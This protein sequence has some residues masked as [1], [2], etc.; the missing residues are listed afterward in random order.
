MI[1][2][3]KMMKMFNDFKK[4]WKEMDACSNGYLSLPF[5]HPLE[6]HIGYHSSDEK[7]LVL[8]NSG[9]VENI[10]SSY[11]IKPVNI[12]LDGTWILEIRLIHNSYEDVFLRL[13]W[14]MIDASR[15]AE[16]SQKAFIN[17][18][19]VWQKL[20]QYM[21]NDVMSFHR[22]KG[23]LGELLYLQSLLANGEYEQNL[24]S[25]IGPEGGDQ[26]FVFE[27]SWS[28]IK[29]VPMASEV[30]TI[31]SLQQ[32]DR[33]EPGKLVVYFLESTVTAA[34]GI[35]LPEKVEEIRNLFCTETVLLD[36]FNM[37]LFMYGYRDK[38]SKEYLKNAFRLVE[39]REYYVKFDFPR[40][41]RKNTATVITTCTYSLSLAGLESFKRR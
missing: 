15:T 12:K 39:V 9:I 40:L 37:K 24:N 2:R 34:G 25:W 7:S 31:S 17:R 28:E 16:N 29:T 11:A 4:K 27:N 33:E 22:Q 19:L 3:M 38:D 36:R 14:D 10:P 18:Y 23:L 13:C 35:S 20:L 41:T 26:D 5:E 30:V 6:F 21:N 1:L 8:M 32:L